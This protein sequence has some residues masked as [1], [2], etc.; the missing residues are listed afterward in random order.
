MFIPLDCNYLFI[1]LN[2][3]TN[4]ELFEGRERVVFAFAFLSLSSVW[5]I[6]TIADFLLFIDSF[7]EGVR[8]TNWIKN[9]KKM[10]VQLQKEKRHSNIKVCLHSL[11]YICHLYAELENET[12]TKEIRW[13]MQRLFAEMTAFTCLG[14]AGQTNF[15]LVFLA[16]WVNKFFLF[17]PVWMRLFCHLY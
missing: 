3:L 16:M 1:C 5:H 15:P 10:N 11:M 4:Y 2:A 9:F 12:N 13:E 17:K 7:T 8:W 6:A 14:Q